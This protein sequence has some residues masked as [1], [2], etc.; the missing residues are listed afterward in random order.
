MRAGLTLIR[1]TV[2]GWVPTAV[3]KLITSSFEALGNVVSGMLSNLT[4]NAVD[5]KPANALTS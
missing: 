5:G 2:K 4:N 3:T 1:F